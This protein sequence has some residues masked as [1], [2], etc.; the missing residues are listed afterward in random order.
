MKVCLL[1]YNEKFYW[2]GSATLKVQR[3]VHKYLNLADVDC[4]LFTCSENQKFF[5]VLFEPLTFKKND[6][7]KV[8]SGGVVPFLNHLLKEKYDVI[9]MIVHRN[10]MVFILLF[11]FIFRIKIVLTVHDTLDFQSIN[12]DSFRQK[13]TFFI[14]RLLIKLSDLILI[15]NLIDLELLKEQYPKKNFSLIKNGVE[16]ELTTLNNMGEDRAIVLFAGGKDNSYKGL[17]FLISSLNKTLSKP[18]LMKCG[19]ERIKNYSQNDFGELTPQEFFDILTKVGV[20]IVP[21]KY[22]SFSITVLE[23]MAVGTPVIL[24]ENCGIAKYLSDGEGCF[25]VKYGDE[26]SL[27]KKIDLLVSN[28]VVWNDL[29]IKAKSTAKNFFWSN[30]IKEYVHQYSTLISG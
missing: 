21:S 27:S 11:R 10:Y 12:L 15:Y 19:Y 4:T 17:D 16:P 30:V 26:D 6:D 23:A 2:E 9:H 29:S 7:G 18:Q 5:S 28:S 13:K 22:D 24:T 3:N 8:I 25:I 14:K 20:L 1:G